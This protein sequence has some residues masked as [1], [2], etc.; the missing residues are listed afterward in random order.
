MKFISEIY[1][2]YVLAVIIVWKLSDNL[3]YNYLSSLCVKVAAFYE[4]C[5][6]VHPCTVGVS[7]RMIMGLIIHSLLYFQK[8]G[9]LTDIEACHICLP[10]C[11]VCP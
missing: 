7:Q 4:K 6:C 8:K 1:S 2:L 11:P 3:A 5:K 10:Y 9:Y